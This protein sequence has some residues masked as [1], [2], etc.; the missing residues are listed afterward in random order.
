MVRL[1]NVVRIIFSDYYSCIKIQPPIKY[2]LEF[3]VIKILL[4]VEMGQCTMS[5]AVAMNM[6][7]FV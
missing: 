4:F 5:T 3:L 2:N 6:K 1:L 7:F